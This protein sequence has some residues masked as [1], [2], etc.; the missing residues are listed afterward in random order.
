MTNVDLG[1]IDIVILGVLG[2]SAIIGLVRGL[3]REVLS[4][5]VWLG[6][7]ILAMAF[8]GPLAQVLEPYIEHASARFF[9]GFA[10]IFVGVL[11]AGGFAQWLTRRLIET[12]GLSGMDRTLGLVFGGLRGA[13][14]CI[15]SLMMLR[16]Y[17]GEEAWW[18]ASVMIEAL[19][20][21]ESV[22]LGA[23]DETAAVV[24]GLTQGV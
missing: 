13:I 3:V 2:I 8:S 23:F 6:A 21:F 7:F 20:P 11:V 15:V 5:A 18:R 14:V 17:A 22:V 10:G 16:P 19:A 24:S 9:V 1:G 4:L 12:S